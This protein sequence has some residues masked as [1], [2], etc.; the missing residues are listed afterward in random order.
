MSFLHH[1]PF[2]HQNSRRHDV[3]ILLKYLVPCE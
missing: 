1:L 2:F 3:L